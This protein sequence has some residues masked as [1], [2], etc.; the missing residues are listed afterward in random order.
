MRRA[1]G[2]R[3]DLVPFYK[4]VTGIV[5]GVFMGVLNRICSLDRFYSNDLMLLYLG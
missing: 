3:G 2:G 4:R 5:M 1:F